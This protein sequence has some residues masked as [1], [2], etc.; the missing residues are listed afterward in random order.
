MNLNPSHNEL[1]LPAR[2]LRWSRFVGVPV[3]YV[4]WRLRLARR[5]VD[6]LE[7]R[8]AGEFGVEDML[9]LHAEIALLARERNRWL[10]KAALQR[11]QQD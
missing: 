4:Q 11:A 7:Q 10:R 2:R 9:P 3:W 5:A 8:L 1:A 6:A